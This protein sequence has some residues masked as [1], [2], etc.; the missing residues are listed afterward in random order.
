[1]TDKPRVHLHPSGTILNFISNPRQG[2][3]GSYRYTKAYAKAYLPDDP[4]TP[5]HI[6]A[7]VRRDWNYDAMVG[8]FKC[9]Y[10]VSRLVARQAIA[11][12]LLAELKIE[13]R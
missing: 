2:R 6:C 13:P 8:G 9:V 4:K 3:L 11:D 10:H 12:E 1:M 7:Q 5:Y